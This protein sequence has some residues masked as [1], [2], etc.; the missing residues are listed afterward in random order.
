MRKDDSETGADQEAE[1]H[2]KTIKQ[3]DAVVVKAEGRV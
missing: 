3:E 2:P 1:G